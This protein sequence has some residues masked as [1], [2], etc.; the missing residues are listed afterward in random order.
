ME[1]LLL[2]RPGPEGEGEMREEGEDLSQVK[3]IPDLLHV[4]QW[5]NDRNEHCY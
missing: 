2:R 4:V 5:V 3:V 1:A